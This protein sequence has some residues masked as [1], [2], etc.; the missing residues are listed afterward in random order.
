[1]KLAIVVVIVVAT[2]TTSVSAKEPDEVVKDLLWFFNDNEVSVLT[3]FNSDS[4]KSVRKSNDEQQSFISERS[5]YVGDHSV[6]AN[7]KINAEVFKPNHLISDKSGG[8]DCVSNVDEAFNQFSSKP[9]DSLPNVI[10]WTV[11]NFIKLLIR[12][13]DIES[14]NYIKLKS[15]DNNYSSTNQQFIWSK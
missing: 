13:I 7:S 1:M 6:S 15:S 3:N 14:V 4:S 12:N 9:L 11:S 2:C 8:K 5:H 10:Q